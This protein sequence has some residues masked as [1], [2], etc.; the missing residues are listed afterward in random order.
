MPSMTA[1]WAASSVRFAASEWAALTLG[2][3]LPRHKAMVG[4]S[5]RNI[6]GWPLRDGGAPSPPPAARASDGET[7]RLLALGG[8]GLAR[9]AL[10][11]IGPDI[12]AG[13]LGAGLGAV[14]SGDR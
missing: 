1:P 4:T 14:D 3:F 11:H 10:F 6:G 12:D 2:P 7:A 9:L 5:M 13:L 8:V